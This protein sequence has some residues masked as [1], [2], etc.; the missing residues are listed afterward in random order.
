M[1]HPLC[2][3]RPIGF[4]LLLHFCLL[5]PLSARTDSSCPFRFEP[6]YMGEGNCFRVILHNEGSDSIPYW[7]DFAILND[8]V[9][10][11]GQ[12]DPA[13]TPEDWEDRRWHFRDN[14]AL[15]VGV[16]DTGYICFVSAVPATRIALAW[17]N[18]GNNIFCYDTVEIAL[19][20]INRSC[21]AID[22]ADLGCIR[23]LSK[24]KDQAAMI[25]A[26]E[27]EQP[28][29]LSLDLVLRNNSSG[30]IHSVDV[31]GPGLDAPRITADREY[32]TYTPSVRQGKDFSLNIGSWDFLFHF[33]VDESVRWRIDSV[34]FVY[35][36]SSGIALC[37]DTL[38][39]LVNGFDCFVGGVS[40][41]VSDHGSFLLSV[42]ER[43]SGEVS[44]RFALERGGDV[45]LW[46]ADMNG[47]EVLRLM[48]GRR[49]EGGEHDVTFSTGSIP[50][51]TY[52]CIVQAGENRASR[53]VRIVR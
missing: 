8:S 7:V 20:R 52:L 47:N 23:L 33:Q 10:V 41:G 19:P 34:D 44:I 29:P 51:G 35:Y 16:P 37:A 25:R 17:G 18:Y 50:S 48:D 9:M 39:F 27:N 38:V 36:D 30:E 49:L 31:T 45:R 12:M 5:L 1:N 11:V 14:R 2:S 21:V 40:E 53:L 26:G 43:S 3:A 32:Y 15:A 13:K 42:T 22:R 24:S 6:E 4:F 46:L 28:V